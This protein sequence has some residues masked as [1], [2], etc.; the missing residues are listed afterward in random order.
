[1]TGGLIQLIIK[2]VQDSPLIN[3]PEI[4][5]FKKIFKQH[6]QFSLYQNQRYLGIANFD[7]EYIK[8]IEKNG[9]LLYNQYFQIEI[10]YFTIN[11]V[12]NN[13]DNINLGYV[14]N[15]LKISSNNID[16]IVLYIS[17]GITKSNWY[18]VPINLFKSLFYNKSLNKIDKK[19]FYTNMLP[20]IIPENDIDQMY[21]IN[22]NY[23]QINP[24]INTLLEQANIWEQLWIQ[25]IINKK[26]F[27][28]L[29][30]YNSYY[31][32]LYLNI[33]NYIFNRYTEIY[34]FN[35]NNSY[36]YFIDKTNKSETERY[37]DYINKQNDQMQDIFDIDITYTY[38]QNNKLNFNNYIDY[39]K[40]NSQI[41][42]LILSMLYG[43]DNL[44]FSFWKKYNVKT[45]NNITNT[46]T[47]NN[48]T[49]I[50]KWYNALT[51]LEYQT[52]YEQSSNSSI[53]INIPQELRSSEY[54]DAVFAIYLDCDKNIWREGILN[55][56][57][58]TN[59]NGNVVCNK[60]NSQVFYKTFDERINSIWW[61]DTS[62]TW[63]WSGLNN[64]AINVAGDLT[65]FIYFQ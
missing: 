21:V 55:D 40:N 65:N 8:I 46:I 42:L 38:C 47:N 29:I 36:F 31:N 9:D 54:G 26:L 60:N 11:K 49:Y 32:H 50:V 2:G 25:E 7:K 23:T 14:V 18:I 10:P 39:V 62:N 44:I 64:S 56:N 33:K 20:D 52:S 48:N 1:M 17:D 63:K 13:F 59:V 5:F 4:T 35:K 16:N 58:Y 19:K 57:T 3:N 24:I 30:T 6:T 27:N 45:N 28:Q 37:F 41:I 15:Y 53:K 43:S 22:I 12:L 51:G 61:D 34:W